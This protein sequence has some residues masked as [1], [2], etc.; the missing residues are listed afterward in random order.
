MILFKRLPTKNTKIP[1]YPSPNSEVDEGESYEIESS[2]F[3]LVK[4]WTGL[5]FE[6]IRQLDLEEF[7]VYQRDAFIAKLRESEKGRQYLSDCYRMEQTKPDMKAIKRY[8]NQHER[9]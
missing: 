3:H 4:E 7:L 8:I 6:E 5:N 1:F 9:S 2:N